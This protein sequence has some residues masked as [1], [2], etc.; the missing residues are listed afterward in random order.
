VRIAGEL[1]LK[2]HTAFLSLGIRGKKALLL[3]DQVLQITTMCGHG[4][5]SAKLTKTVIEKVKAGKVTPE[6]GARL[7]AQ[8]CPCGIFNT[9]RCSAI[10]E[11]CQ[12]KILFDKPMGMF[13]QSTKV[14]GPLRYER[15]KHQQEILHDRG[16]RGHHYRADI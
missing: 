5:V 8:P 3:D 12:K 16:D 1:D 6:V 14:R 11:E 10:L 4:M 13:Y 7:L 15:Q 9:E 2:P